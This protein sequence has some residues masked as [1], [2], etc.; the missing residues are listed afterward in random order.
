MTTICVM[1]LGYIG[2]PTAAL[3]ANNNYQVRGVD[4]NE[5]YVSRLRQG[6]LPIEEPGLHTI[7][8]SA[9]NSG[10]LRIETTPAAADVFF[11]CVPTPITLD[12]KADLG[13]VISATGAILPHVEKG[14]LIILESTSPPGT[15]RSVI[16]RRLEEKGL[17]PGEDVYVAYSPERVL[18]GRILQELIANPRIVGGINPESARRARILY[19]S[20]VEG[21]V[22]E[23]DATTAELVKIVENTFR[24]ISLAY[25]NELS[26]LCEDLGTDVWEVVELASQHP[27]VKLLKPGPGVGGHCI[28]VDPWFLVEQFGEKAKLIET[29]RRVN[30]QQPIF[31]AQ[32][33]AHLLGNQKGAKVAVWGIAYKG[34][35]DDCRESPAFALIRELQRCG[36]RVALVD[37][38]VTSAKLHYTVLQEKVFPDFDKARLEKE[39]QV[40]SDP[41]VGSAAAD[42]I[43]LLADHQEFLKVAP[44]MLRKRVRSARVLDTRR[45]LDKP[46]WERAGFDF[47]LLG[48]TK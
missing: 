44:A 4:I 20:F 38:H 19:E 6:D 24:D 15:T 21:R 2:L 34:N 45:F 12:K 33:A 16:C 28:S 37:P 14:N 25:V 40:Q 23:T 9:I 36:V 17:R 11:I 42:L 10:R 31:V 13:A 8:Q 7:V 47:H 35:V 32:K 29:A 39:M 18:P 1:G 41:L 48:K 46:E 22:F 43:V 3:L 5:D 27:R 30:D 26:R